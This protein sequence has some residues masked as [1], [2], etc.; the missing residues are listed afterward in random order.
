MQ[1]SEYNPRVELREEPLA[2]MRRN[3]VAYLA[4]HGETW[5]DVVH[6][7][8]EMDLDERGSAFAGKDCSW[9]YTP[10]T[11]WTHERVHKFIECDGDDYYH[12]WATSMRNPPTKGD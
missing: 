8:T 6:V 4:I 2:S 7:D 9:P 5:E 10:I 12:Q 3:L 11:V 1:D